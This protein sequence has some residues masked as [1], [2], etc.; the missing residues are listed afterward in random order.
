MMFNMTRWSPFSP[1]YQLRREIDDLFGRTL[2]QAVPGAAQDW[3]WTPAV[4][5]KH[6]DGKYMIRVALPGIDPKDVEVFVQDDEMVVKGQRKSENQK[7]EGH[8]FA[9]ELSYG[10]FERRFTLPEGVDA[11]KVTAKFNHGLLEI[12]VPEPVTLE[13]RKITVEVAGGQREPAAVKA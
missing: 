2:G 1:M 6:E 7:D 13:P 10:A 8:Y 11:E 5:G 3:M 4:E 9:R 12:T